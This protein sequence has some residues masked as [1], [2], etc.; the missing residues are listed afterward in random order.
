MN[1]DVS[2]YQDDMKM[3]LLELTYMNITE[4][5]YSKGCGVNL[6]RII[7]KKVKKFVVKDG[8]LYYYKKKGTV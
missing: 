4:N 2:E 1:S 7:R 6:Q 3:D 5:K 8:E